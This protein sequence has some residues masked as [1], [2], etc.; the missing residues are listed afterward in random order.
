MNTNTKTDVNE[1]IIHEKALR[2]EIGKHRDHAFN[3]IN[4]A[5]GLM[6]LDNDSLA[7]LNDVARFYKVTRRTIQM[8][9]RN[10]K[11]E[12]Q[13]TGVKS[14]S[15]KEFFG[16]GGKNNLPPKI[17]SKKGYKLITIGEHSTKVSNW[18]NTVLTKDSIIRVGMLLRDSEVAKEFRDQVTKILNRADVNTIVEVRD[19]QLRQKAELYDKMTDGVPKM[20]QESLLTTIEHYQATIKELE[21][22]AEQEL[23]EERQRTQEAKAARKKAEENTKL[24][25]QLAT[26]TGEKLEDV[27]KGLEKSRRK[28]DLFDRY[29]DSGLNMTLQ[30]FCKQYLDDL[31]TKS[32]IA[33]LQADGIL[34][35]NRNTNGVYRTRKGFEQWLVNVPVK[36]YNGAMKRTLMITPKGSIK[37]AQKYVDDPRLKESWIDFGN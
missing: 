10:N 37:L 18:R 1:N 6:L 14:I 9:I 17:E 4:Q 20:A 32:F 23:Q 2:D 3:I 25:Q 29:I 7:P 21:R 12:F 31:K 19:E 33:W 8:L 22:K 34:Y 24:F 15:S 16:L 35:E 28:S 27:V 5:G 11:E 30:E 26:E 36:Q 13:K